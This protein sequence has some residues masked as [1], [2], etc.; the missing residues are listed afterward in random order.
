MIDSA[1]LHEQLA[2]AMHKPPWCVYPPTDPWGAGIG[3]RS[4]KYTIG[5]FEFSCDDE[6]A[7]AAVNAL[8]K[9]LAVYEAAEAWRDDRGE[10]AGA[11]LTRDRG[12]ADRLI[13]AIDAARSST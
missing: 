7:V 9:L 5:G 12:A 11:L 8:P 4:T 3:A 2:A 13:A 6:L 1:K 10:V